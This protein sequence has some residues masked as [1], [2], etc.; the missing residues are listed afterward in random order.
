MVGTARLT[1]TLRNAY[2]YLYFQ[3]QVAC[4]E[5]VSQRPLVF[6][7]TLI[8]FSRGIENPLRRLLIFVVPCRMNSV[9]SP[10]YG[11]VWI[12]FPCMLVV[13]CH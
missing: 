13:I 8:V 4:D 7:N 12:L 9:A 2:F 3:N 1:E 5:I 11:I 6:D 10:W